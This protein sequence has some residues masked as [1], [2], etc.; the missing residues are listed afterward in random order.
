MLLSGYQIS[1]F[2]YGCLYNL[3]TLDVYIVNQPVVSSPFGE[4]DSPLELQLLFDVSGSNKI[5]PVES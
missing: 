2:A 4:N 3:F 5:D 1:A